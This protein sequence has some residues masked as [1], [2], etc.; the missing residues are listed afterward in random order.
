MS[1]QAQDSP[2]PERILQPNPGNSAEV[3]K[4]CS[5]WAA[6]AR[7]SYYK[8]KGESSDTG[9]KQQRRYG[10]RHGRSHV[11]GGLPD[12]FSQGLSLQ[13]GSKL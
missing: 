1:Y 3:K 12:T 9:D 7:G 4:P 8:M 5:G 11:R 13:Q 2:Q 6:R 10:Y